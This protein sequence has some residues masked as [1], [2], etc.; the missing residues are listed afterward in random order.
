MYPDFTLWQ[1]LYDVDRLTPMVGLLLFIIV[2]YVIVK[3]QWLRFRDIISKIP[4]LVIITLLFGTYTNFVFQSGHIIPISWSQIISLFSISVSTLDFIGIISWLLIATLITLS[5]L[6]RKIKTQWS[7]VLVLT[8]MIV[9]ILLGVLFT[10]WDS[11]IG[12]FN[13]WFFSIWSFVS[14]S[15]I[16]QLWWSVY[17]IG[18]LISAR[19]AVC[20]G[21]LVYFRHKL[22]YRIGYWWAAVFMIWYLV[23]LHYQ[24]YP[25]HLIVNR[26]WLYMDLRTYC[27]IAIACILWYLWYS[28]PTVHRF[29]P[30]IHEDTVWETR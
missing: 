19:S 6:S 15:R 25:R 1:T 23:I 24:H 7:Y 18:L 10:L 28:V 2:L 21:I 13:D 9:L 30:S 14:Q 12:K 22:W 5:Q 20:V 16:A 17:P 3:Y 26:W 8:Y 29:V 4:L 11:V 27:C